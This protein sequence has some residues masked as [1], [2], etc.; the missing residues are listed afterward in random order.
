MSELDIPTDLTDLETASRETGIKT[1]TIRTW[2]RTGKL[3]AWKRGYYNM[4]SRA[5]L[6][7]V[8]MDRTS[9]RPRNTPPYDDEST[10]LRSSK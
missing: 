8:I 2:V 9:V 7:Q 1:G 5:E 10:E 6:A 3:R 4:V